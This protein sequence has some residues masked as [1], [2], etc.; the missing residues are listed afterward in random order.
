MQCVISLSNSFDSFHQ[1]ITLE[2]TGF[3]FDGTLRNYYFPS[4]KS[5]AL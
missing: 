1:L 2:L 3:D 5:L 4:Y